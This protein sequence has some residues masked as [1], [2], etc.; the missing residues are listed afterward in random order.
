VPLPGVPLRALAAGRKARSA[1]VLAGF[2]RSRGVSRTS[3]SPFQ[4]LWVCP[5]GLLR[6]PYEEDKM[7]KRHIAAY[8]FNSEFPGERIRFALAHELAHLIMHQQFYS[9][10]KRD[11]EKEANVFASEF[12]MPASDIISDLRFINTVKLNVERL[13]QLNKA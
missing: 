2:H 12:L 7:C 10:Q 1:G 6:C 13:L 9:D 3:A 11:I 5:R 8:F 4:P